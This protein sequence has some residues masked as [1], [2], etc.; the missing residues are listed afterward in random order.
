MS[1]TLKISLQNKA[2]A[3]KEANERIKKLSDN[4]VKG[5]YGKNMQLVDKS[6]LKII[7]DEEFKL[8]FD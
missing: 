3:L 7:T 6:T 1:E 8:K 4:E 2:S 5:L